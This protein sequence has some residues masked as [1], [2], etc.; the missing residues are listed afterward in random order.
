[1]YPQLRILSAVYFIAMIGYPIT[2]VGDEGVWENLKQGGYV[3]LMRHATA[4]KTGDPLILKINDCSVQRNLSP[5]GRQEAALIGLVFHSRFIPVS[6][7]L[8]SRASQ[9]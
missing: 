7:V 3:I 4:Q 2:G 6:E 5:K 1:M 9:N 8:S